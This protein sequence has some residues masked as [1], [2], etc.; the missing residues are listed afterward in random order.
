MNNKKLRI[1]YHRNH[2]ITNEIKIK[3]NRQTLRA[4]HLRSMNFIQMKTWT[5]CHLVW[6]P[7]NDN[8]QQLRDSI[9]GSSGSI[10]HEIRSTLSN[11]NWGPPYNKMVKKST[12]FVGGGPCFKWAFPPWKCHR[13]SSYLTHVN[14]CLLLISRKFYLFLKLSTFI[15]ESEINRHFRANLVGCRGNR[16]HE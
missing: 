8:I 13:I 2:L 16:N 4:S 15:L 12:F 5:D 11:L 3:S 14:K 10:F 6:D 7:K 1:I 9:G